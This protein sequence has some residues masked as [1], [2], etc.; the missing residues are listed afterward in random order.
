MFNLHNSCLIKWSMLG[1]LAER[2]VLPWGSSWLFSLSVRIETSLAGMNEA[3]S[4]SDTVCQAKPVT[5]SPP[6]FT[7][8]YLRAWWWLVN[9]NLV[10]MILPCLVWELW[11]C[12]FFWRWGPE[13]HETCQMICSSCRFLLLSWMLRAGF[14]PCKMEF[15]PQGRRTALINRLVLTS[16][17]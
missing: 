10:Q 16:L 14:A 7:E 11:E 12:C 6:K 5:P 1:V 2:L 9:L 17:T 4:N 8:P 3:P 13:C 15:S